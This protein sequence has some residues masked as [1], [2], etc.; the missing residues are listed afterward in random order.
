M[1]RVRSAAGSPPPAVPGRGA[2]SLANWPRAGGEALHDARARAPQAGWRPPRRARRQAGGRR[3]RI[4]RPTEAVADAD[5]PS[6]RTA[7]RR[8]RAAPPRAR[9]PAAGPRAGDDAPPA[10]SAG[11]DGRAGAELRRRLRRGRWRC[12]GR[13][14]RGRA[15]QA[16][17]HDR[18]ASVDRRLA[19]AKTGGELGEQRRADADDDGQHHHLDARGDD[20]AQNLLGQEGGLV[21]EPNGM[22]TKPASVVSLNSIRVMKSWTARMKKAISTRSQANSSTAIWT[23]F[24]KNDVSPSSGSIA[25]RMG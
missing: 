8:R 20:V 6:R 13:K 25:S 23:K 22:S 1:T 15:A 17:E 14:C 16:G 21:E 4:R 11:A 5:P 19:A 10:A 24:S 18:R 12:R 9:A 2:A 7:A 3:R